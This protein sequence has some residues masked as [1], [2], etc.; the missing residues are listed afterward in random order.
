MDKGLI[1]N[2]KS[3]NMSHAFMV[4]NHAEEQREKVRMVMNCK[5]LND[6]TIFDGYYIPNKMDCK[7]SYWQI[8]IDEESIHLTA[9]SAPSKTL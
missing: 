1:K 8:K 7:S 4:R 9:F 5:K 6:N 2:N 3:P